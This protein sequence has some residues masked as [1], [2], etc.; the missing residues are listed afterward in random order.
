MLF[1]GSECHMGAPHVAWG[2]W[3]DGMDLRGD[4]RFDWGIAGDPVGEEMRRLVTAANQVRWDNPALRSDTLSITHEDHHNS[5]LGF[6]RWHQDNLVLTVIN[7]GDTDFVHH[8][9]GVL[10]GGQYGRWSQILCTQ[11]SAFGGWDGAGNTFYEP[12][13]EAD[14]RIYIN[15]PKWSVVMFC[16]C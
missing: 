16:L 8:S 5:V 10:T 12:W 15:L 3:H 7:L 1:M 9:Y 4:H 14:G 2:Y 13:T 6:K 11:D